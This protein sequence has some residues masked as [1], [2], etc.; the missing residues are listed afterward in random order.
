MNDIS[1]SSSEYS[2]NLSS[3]KTMLLK[4]FIYYSNLGERNKAGLISQSNFLQM[5]KESKIISGPF[6]TESADLLIRG[7]LKKKKL[8][9]FQDFL[10][11]FIKIS[12]RLYPEEFPTMKTECLLRILSCHLAPLYS[13]LLSQNAILNLEISLTPPLLE[14]LSSIKPYLLGLYK[15]YFPWELKSDESVVILN[16]KSEKGLFSLLHKYQVY[17]EIITRNL[18]S[19]LW[20][21]LFECPP[22]FIPLL[23]CG[24]LTD[25]GKAFTLSKFA[26]FLILSA[27]FGRFRQQIPTLH[28]KFVFLLENMEICSGR[29]EISGGSVIISRSTSCSQSPRHTTLHPQNELKRAYD[30]LK[31]STFKK[32]VSLKKV[33]DLLKALNNRSTIPTTSVELIFFAVSKKTKG[34][35]SY[36]EFCELISRIGS[37]IAETHPAGASFAEMIVQ[38]E[39]YQCNTSRITEEIDRISSEELSETLDIWRDTLIPILQFYSNNDCEKF[40]FQSLLQF[41]TDFGLFPD[42]I[43]KQKLDQVF[44]MFCIE[45]S[46]EELGMNPVVKVLEICAAQAFIP[47]LEVNDKLISVLE[48]VVH[49]EGHIRLSGKNGLNRNSAINSI[50]DK[51][52]AKQAAKSVIV[53][54]EGFDSLFGPSKRH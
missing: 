21:N 38:S 52:N 5:L 37:K 22:E 20:Q 3:M 9:E 24:H 12:E 44:S 23:V 26:S 54:R 28:E 35:L 19:L 50:G 6:T 8:C 27:A 53:E 29:Y 32:E 34:S 1:T 14:I 2:S 4:L 39:W 40:S 51:L 43:T 47:G 33:K 48:R 46:S 41:A 10:D 31:Y 36:E 15:L 13:L 25:A 11:M 49:S 18:F 7:T 45:E 16:K 30:Y 42:L 17:P